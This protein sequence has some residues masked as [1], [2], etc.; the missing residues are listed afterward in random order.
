MTLVERARKLLDGHPVAIEGSGGNRT[1]FAAACA[2]V[3]G[4]G[5]SPEEAMPLM[6]EYNGGCQ[7]PWAP[8]DLEP[9]ISTL[10]KLHGSRA[11]T[12]FRR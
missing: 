9:W 7:P 11:S 5:F 4:F 1:T 2:L 8:R 10:P 3:W 12:A 6:L